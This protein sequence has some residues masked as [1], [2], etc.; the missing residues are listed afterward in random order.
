M[1]SL[2][3]LKRLAEQVDAIY[4]HGPDSEASEAMVLLA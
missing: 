4:L 3:G 1:F 2:F